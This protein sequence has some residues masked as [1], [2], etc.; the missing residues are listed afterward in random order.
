MTQ[1][2]DAELQHCVMDA[3]AHEA[4]MAGYA[5][6]VAAS[7]HERPS[8]L[9]RP[10]LSIDGAQW[11]ALYGENLQDGV[12][13]FGDSPIA[14]MADFDQAWGRKLAEEGQKP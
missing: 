11:C 9:Y 10:R 2:L 4:R 8:V 3:I 14:A 13:G 7:S 1:V 12:A 6:Q 5:I